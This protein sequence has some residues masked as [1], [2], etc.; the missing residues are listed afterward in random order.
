MAYFK[1]YVDEAGF[2]YPSY[3]D[4]L[5][6]MIA[7][8]KGIYGQ[9]LYLANDSQD[10]QMLSIFALKVYDTFQAVA[11]DYNNRSPKTAIGSA[12]DSLVKI[13]GIRR[14]S[15][16]YSTC[17]VE[18]VGDPDTII[19]GGIIKDTSNIKWDLPRRVVI[20][21]DGRITV[22]ATCQ[23]LGDI[24]A[25]VGTLTGI[26][27]PTKGWVGV[28]NHV[29]ATLGAAIETDAELRMRQTISVANPAQTVIES[30]TGAIAALAGVKRYK[31]YE[32]DTN[33]TDSNGIPSHSISA[34]VEG[35]LAEEIGKAIYLRKGPGCGTHGTS[36]VKIM[37][38]ANIEI[39]IK[40][41]R[42]SYIDIDVEVR[43]VKLFGYTTDIELAIKQNIDEYIS[44]IQ[45]GQS[46]YLSSIWATAVR[47]IADLK[48]PSFSI[49]DVKMKK[50][51][52]EFE[53]RD[54]AVAHDQVARFGSCK[55]TV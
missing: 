36:T 50:N 31:V 23:V 30:T 48:E 38:T 15:A 39:P 14:K 21:S 45:I 26:D 4:I 8:M 13:N 7:Q 5:N 27:T 10:Y 37:N 6:D 53:V 54:I 20:P 25:T 43:I 41:S 16:S 24:K 29:M 19:T 44:S 42:P 33:K 40:F 35:G 32:N 3:Q 47:A 11:L 52:G 55:V 28:T 17:D 1:P 49:I 34:V 12:L 22:T 46:V 9:D 2:H 51:N 18:I